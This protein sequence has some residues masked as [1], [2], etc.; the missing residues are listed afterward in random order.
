MIFNSD[1]EKVMKH[2]CFGINDHSEMDSNKTVTAN[3][4]PKFFEKIET[5][6]TLKAYCRVGGGGG[7]KLTIKNFSM[8]V[9]WVQPS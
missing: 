9:E 8:E 1:D 7:H 2:T 4:W 6:M 5:G 3:D